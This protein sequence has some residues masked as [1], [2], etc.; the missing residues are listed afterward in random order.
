LELRVQRVEVD[1]P[2]E[3]FLDEA[4]PAGAT[5]VRAHSPGRAAAA[6]NA[7]DQQGQRDRFH[8]PPDAPV[9]VLEV[10]LR[11]AADFSDVSPGRAA[12][13][14]SRGAARV[15]GPRGR[16]RGAGNGSAGGRAFPDPLA[17]CYALG[18][19]LAGRT[20]GARLDGGSV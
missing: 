3:R 8:I 17:R 16:S 2:A 19:S 10:C 1:G 9:L 4:S 15:T 11:D 20:R 13:G 6:S 18:R 14:E 5:P 12:G 7:D